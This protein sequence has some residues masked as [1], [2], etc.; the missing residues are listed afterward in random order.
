MGEGDTGCWSKQAWL[1]KELSLT[2]SE[3]WF[4]SSFL[5]AHSF[6][7]FKSGAV[8]GGAQRPLPPPLPR[9]GGGLCSRLGFPAQRVRVGGC[10]S[11]LEGSSAE[12]TVKGGGWRVGTAGKPPGWPAG[13]FSAPSSCSGNEAAVD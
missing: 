8:R 13:S 10:L 2:G 9:W 11:D 6:N 5:P 4:S 12:F 1:L 3:A 7:P